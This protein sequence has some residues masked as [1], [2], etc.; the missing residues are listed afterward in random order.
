MD[1]GSRN[2]EHGTLNTKHGSRN[3]EFEYLCHFKHELNGL[4][5]RTQRTEHSI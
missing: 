1:H 3:T 4:Y 5:L 2:M